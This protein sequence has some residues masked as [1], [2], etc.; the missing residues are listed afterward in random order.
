MTRVSIF[1]IV[2]SCAACLNSIPL[3]AAKLKPTKVARGVASAKAQGQAIIITEIPTINETSKLCGHIHHT[4]NVKNAKPKMT[5]EKYSES[6]FASSSI[7]GFLFIAVSSKEIK[8][9]NVE[10]SKSFEAR[11]WMSASILTVALSTQDPTDLYIA[12]LSPVKL[13]SSKKPSP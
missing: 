7:R 9:E 2:S 4:K 11:K 3:C 13:D 12:S 6:L 8:E 5:E 10:C 1:A